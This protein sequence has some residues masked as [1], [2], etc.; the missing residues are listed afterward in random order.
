MSAEH[1]IET[2]LLIGRAQR[3]ATVGN[4]PAELD[5]PVGEAQPA[6]LATTKAPTERVQ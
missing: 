2:A 1:N 6:V 5:R 3:D 4:S